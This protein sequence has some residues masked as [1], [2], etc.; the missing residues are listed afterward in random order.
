MP[1]TYDIEIGTVPAKIYKNINVP[2]DVETVENLGCLTGAV[3]VKALNS[4]KNAANYNM[5]V[6]YPKSNIIVAAWKTNKPLELLPGI[7]DISV[8]MLPKHLEKGVRVDANKETVVDLGC[9]SGSLLVKA[10]D[11]NNKESRLTIMLKKP[12][13]SEIVAY[14][15]SGK[16]AEVAPGTYNVDLLSLPSQGK[17]DVKI[18]AGEETTVEFLINPSTPLRVDAERSRSIKPRPLPP[19]KP[20]K[21]NNKKS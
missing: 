8:E 14:G 19:K 20:G 4:K 3:N 6:L 7:Y 11:E 13:A 5:L 15:M 17:K 12:G 9:V 2:K 1:G 16:P 18:N 21:T 10:A